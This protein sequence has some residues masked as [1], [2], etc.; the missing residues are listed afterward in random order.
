VTLNDL[1]ADSLIRFCSQK[2]FF[3]S[4]VHFKKLSTMKI[5]VL[6]TGMVGNAIGSKLVQLGHQVMMGSRTANNE[7]ALTWVKQNSSNASQGTFA[8]ASKFGE[9]IFNCTN[10]AGTLDALNQAGAENLKG[11]ILIDI[12]NALDFSKG[13]PPTLFVCNTDSLGEQIQ[14]R[15]LDG[16]GFSLSC[17]PLPTARPGQ[18]ARDNPLLERAP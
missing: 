14:R 10:G 17:T 7:K 8:D 1:F 2:F 18:S 15:Q 3:A 9:V 11:K 6:G 16:L 12:S 5:A 13:M 4:I